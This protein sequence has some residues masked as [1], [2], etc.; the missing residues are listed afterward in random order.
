MAISV[1]DGVL[2]QDHQG[3]SNADVVGRDGLAFAA[4]SDDHAAE[5]FLHIAQAG[6]ERENRHDLA[7]DGDIE[8]RG[9]S[10]ALFFR[11]LAD[12]NLAEKTIVCIDDAAPGDRRRID[13]QA[14]K[15]AAF[16]RVSALGSVLLMPS[17]FRRRCMI[18][19]N[20]RVPSL[21]QA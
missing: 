19:E 15:T 10:R 7:G 12:R 18:A 1:G 4:R 17:F 3:T 21:R 13:I 14:G 20:F 5:A 9:P 16:F 8:S 6:G 11:T 2:H